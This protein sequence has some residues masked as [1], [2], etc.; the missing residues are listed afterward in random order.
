M[1]QINYLKEQAIQIA[2]ED[3]GTFSTV[4]EF[5]DEMRALLSYDSP[6]CK[7][8]IWI[9]KD[10]HN[11]HLIWHVQVRPNVVDN[12]YYFIDAK[13]GE[14]LEKYNNTQTDGPA[15]GTAIDLNGESQTVHTY[16]KDG[17]DTQGDDCSWID[18]II[19]PT[20]TLPQLPQISLFQ[21]NFPSETDVSSQTSNLDMRLIPSD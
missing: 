9:D 16:L 14:I 19:F 21:T 12:W 15:E 1:D 5:N 7:Q 10:D 20:I 2:L 11:P 4:A 8:Y 17:W 13:T 3:I 18:Y 6:V